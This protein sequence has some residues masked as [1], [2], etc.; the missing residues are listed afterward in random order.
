[1]DASSFSATLNQA[2]V[3]NAFQATGNGTDRVAVFELAGSPLVSGRNVLRT[4][5]EGI[6]P[7]TT[8]SA[9]DG[10]AITFFID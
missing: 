10:D 4:S 2:D 3:T 5:I 7:G 1:M 9:S 6:V 8:R